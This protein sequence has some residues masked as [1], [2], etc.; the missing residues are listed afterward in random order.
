MSLEKARRAIIAATQDG[1]PAY[2]FGE[3]WLAGDVEG[4]EL[5]LRWGNVLA[6][7][8][9]R[10]K[11]LAVGDRVRV[12]AVVSEG[13]TPIVMWILALAFPF[14]LLWAF[15]NTFW[16][17]LSTA[18]EIGRAAVVC[19][20]YGIAAF[21]IFRKPSSPSGAFVVRAKGFLSRALLAEAIEV[22]AIARR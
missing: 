8:I 13:P 4:D 21:L 17:A 22:E 2:D 18:V 12:H 5:D 19:G 6:P 16:P 14:V 7:K 20:L 1:P 9:V 15:W 10:V 11:L 3:F